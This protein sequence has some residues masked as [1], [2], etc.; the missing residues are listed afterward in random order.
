MNILFLTSA[1]P[2]KSGFSTA[3]KRP[4][5]G[6]ASLMA[7]LKREGHTIHFSDEY[8]RPSEILDT[9]FLTK[10][11]IDFVGI[12]S[13]TICYRSTLT[14]FEKL[15]ALRESG[16]WH[17]RILVGGPHT[18]VGLETIPDY[19][20]H[21]V[22]GEGEVSVPRIVNGE[23]TE[24]VVRGEFVEDLDSIPR[25]A[26]EELIHRP[27]DWTHVWSRNVPLYTLNTSRGCPFGCTF[28]S[29]GSVWGKTY[30]YQSAERVVDD[31]EFMIRYYGAK[32][33]F[34]RE[35]HFTL[36]KKRIIDF[37][38]LILKKNIKIEW[39]CETRADDLWDK[40]YQQLMA[41][42]G[43]STFYIG[44]ESGS[45]RMLELFNKKET[46]DQF[47]RAFQIARQVGIKTYASMVLG[48]PYE[49]EEDRRLTGDFL[50]ALKPDYIGNN[51]YVGIPGSELYQWIREDG[52]YEYQDEF[53]ILYPVNY[54]KN[55]DTQYGGAEYFKVYGEEDI[56]VPP[57]RVQPHSL[58]AT[59]CK[60]KGCADSPQE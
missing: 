22:V 45:N 5:L 33:I 25:P 30:R 35:D 57:N 14:L 42:A 6:L 50:K 40:E 17:G 41:D 15:Q 2:K 56:I 24:R 9:D 27:Y 3:E 34:F 4:P 46:P 58:S 20:D 55:A 18:S 16:K 28:C 48:V 7:V 38:N 53:G 37:C 21:I 1:A 8:L 13:N 26:W 11:G 60:R 19:V 39:M 47:L 23:I 36:N 10:H 32:C 12:Y 43:C 31:V 51:V 52:L 44:V 49:T 59:N 29:V 54:L